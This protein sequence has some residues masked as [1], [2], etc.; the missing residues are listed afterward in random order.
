MSTKKQSAAARTK[1]SSRA[2]AAANR[3]TIGN[4]KAKLPIEND[5]AV[6]QIRELLQRTYLV[7]HPKAKIDVKRRGK[8]VVLVR[9]IDPIFASMDLSERNDSVSPV[10]EELPD[11][12]FT[13]VSS[14]LLLAPKEVKA[15]FGNMDFED[16]LPLPE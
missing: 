11:Q 8:W 10:L 16:P 15:S 6:K 3:V 7:Q 13:Q 9:I 4:G 1:P 2:S 5:Q 14:L 12:V